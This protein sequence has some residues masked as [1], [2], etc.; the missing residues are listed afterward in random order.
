M[1]VFT[2]ISVNNYAA[3]AIDEE[4]EVW[5]LAGRQRSWCN[6]GLPPKFVPKITSTGCKTA[7]RNV[8]R[9]I[10]MDWMR[11]AGKRALKT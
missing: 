10:P 1:T 2:D 3:T 9:P 4:G 11:K 5:V 7:E 8:E 6:L